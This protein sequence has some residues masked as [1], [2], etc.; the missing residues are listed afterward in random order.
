MAIMNSSLV[1]TGSVASRALAGIG[2][3][4]V[5]VGILSLRAAGNFQ[6]SMNMLEAV[7]GSTQKQ[8]AALKEEAIALGKDFKLPNVS[9]KNAADAMVE[10]S[11]AGMT[12]KQILGATRGALQLGL[13]ANIGFADSAQLS[14]RSLKAFDLSG[15]QAVRVANLFAAGA[16]K[17]TAEITDLALGVQNAGAQFH[18]A[19]LSI[20]DLVTSLSIMA[21]NALSGEY[22][23]T[24]LKTMLIRLQSPTDKARDV[25]DKYGISIFNAKGEMKSMPNI[26]AQFQK[27]LGKL[28]QEQR[29]QALTTIFGVRANQAMRILMNEGADAYVKY[30]KEVTGTNAAQAIAE[31]RTKGFNGALGA[32]GSAVETLAIQL[33]DHLLPVA[34]KAIRG[35]AN[36]VASIDPN[37]IVAIFRPFGQAVEWFAGLVRA[38]TPLQAILIGVAAA[39]GGLLVISMVTGLVTALVG[40][41]TALG[42]A[43]LAN[44]IG[45]VAAALIGL[46]AA[47]Y[48]AYQHSETFRNAVNAAFEFLKSLI[49][50]IVAFGKSVAEVFQNIWRLVSP[51]LTNL[52]NDVR[53]RFMLMHN[54]AKDN[55][56]R[57]MAVIRAAWTIIST[58]WKTNIENIL[59][60][61]KIFAAA[62]RGDWSEVWNELKAIVSR[63]LSAVV[64]VVRSFITLI[65]NAAILLGKAVWEGIKQGLADLA[66]KVHTAVSKVVDAVQGVVGLAYSA[67]V[68]VG[69]AIINGVVAGL[70]GLFGAVKDK[71]VG[72]IRGA[73]SAAGGILHGSGD[74]MFTKEAV[75]KPLAQGITEGMLLGLQDLPAKMSEKMKAVVEAAK[76]TVEAQSQTLSAAMNRLVGD[77]M[78]LFD[79]QTNQF[80]TKAEKALAAFD[81]SQQVAANK[82]KIQELVDAMEEAHQKLLVFSATPREQLTQNEGETNDAFQ[83]RQYEAEQKWQEQFT[84]LYT[85]FQDA[86]TALQDEKEA[87]RLAKKREALV[88]QAEESRK[89]YNA[90]RDLQKR[91]LEDQLNDLIANLQKHPQKWDFYQ[92]KVL[93]VIRS[94]VRDFRGAGQMLGDSFAAGL[95]Q[96]VENIEKAGNKLA[97]TIAQYL[98]LHSPAE[99]GPLS[100]L[101]TWWSSFGST[102]VSGLDTSIVSR[103]AAGLAGGMGALSTSGSALT[104]AGYTGTNLAAGNVYNNFYLNVEGSLIRQQ[105]LADD[106]YRLVSEQ[107]TRGKSLLL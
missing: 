87:Q 71:I 33:G 64:T 21:D 88:L 90:Q 51:I 89:Q 16:N 99:K 22:A 84:Q 97:A 98:H 6:Q 86:Q 105:D 23:G 4:T 67:A 104:S 79:A 39:L 46:G 93:A 58:I 101:D 59:S 48:Y 82:K 31:A 27:H 11:K 14:A 38:S 76:Q 13:A 41:F 17:S 107:G 75:G 2:L 25:M 44:P 65:L 66:G 83:A 3:A 32:L 49:P 9:A 5:G 103:A 85:A 24:A 18:G 53:D 36:I 61:F 34:E 20:E 42:A 78:T 63:T 15:D 77:V 37:T 8:M 1:R 47:L 45:L 26:V 56:D 50:G 74:F 19:G 68:A 69:Q 12:T 91:N 72:G 54:F 70:S 95:E 55:M 60:V 40:A 52:V 28:T 57:I 81:L 43:M 80:K 35:L 73:I 10:L 30:R 96:S 100:T 7:S 92:Q 62:L 106:L 94:Y 29:E 102:L